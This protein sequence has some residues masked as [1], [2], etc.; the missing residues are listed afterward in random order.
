MKV[1]T[2]MKSKTED[3]TVWTGTYLVMFIC[4]F[5]FCRK[6]PATRKI[7][8]FYFMFSLVFVCLFSQR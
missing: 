6:L 1:S 8:L 5:S 3:S 2:K 7:R 4:N